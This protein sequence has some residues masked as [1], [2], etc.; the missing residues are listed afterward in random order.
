ME[1]SSEVLVADGEPTNASKLPR[2]VP[3]MKSAQGRIPVSACISDGARPFELKIAFED[4]LN[5]QRSGCLDVES[6]YGA[7][8]MHRDK[9]S[10]AHRKRVP[11]VDDRAGLRANNHSPRQGF[12]GYDGAIYMESQME[13]A[14][15]FQRIHPRLERSLFVPE[16]SG[17]S[18][19]G[20]DKLPRSDG[21]RELQRL[22]RLPGKCEGAN[23]E[24]ATSQK[25]SRQRAR[26]SLKRAAAVV[27]DFTKIQVA[28]RSIR[29][30]AKILKG[31]KTS[32]SQ[33]SSLAPNGQEGEQ[34]LSA[35]LSLDTRSRLA[36]PWHVVLKRFNWRLT[37]RIA[38]GWEFIRS[39]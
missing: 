17:A 33:R 36:A 20:R 16:D 18:A 9:Q 25:R 29:Q 4:S 27:H 39:K 5:L 28:K 7:R 12:R 26:S 19:Y 21:S 24:H 32:A 3:E 38:N 13:S 34:R 14:E 10:F 23:E 31:F 22:P 6:D 15:D 11:D 1:Y 2:P 35:P 30:G 37:S 8:L